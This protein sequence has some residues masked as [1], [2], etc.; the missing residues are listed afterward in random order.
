MTN[1]AKLFT[2]HR[3]GQQILAEDCD[4]TGQLTV[5]LLQRSHLDRDLSVV[6]FDGERKGVGLV[7]DTQVRAEQL[8]RASRAG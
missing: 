4:Q 8:D 2:S 7:T 5:M 3:L 1:A 6:E